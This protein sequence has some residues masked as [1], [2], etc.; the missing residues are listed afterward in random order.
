MEW[1]YASFGRFSAS[2]EVT[3]MTEGIAVSACQ[4]S[5]RYRSCRGIDLSRI[6]ESSQRW[7][8]LIESGVMEGGRR[9]SEG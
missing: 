2:C 9:G 8:L 3:D 5:W 1:V 7:E 4:V 6:S